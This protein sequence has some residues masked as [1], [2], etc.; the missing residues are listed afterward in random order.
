MSEKTEDSL[1]LTIERVMRNTAEARLPQMMV[2]LRENFDLIKNGRN[3]VEL[4]KH[5]KQ[6]CLVVGAGPSLTR[7]KHLHLL[8]K[9]GWNHDIISCDRML[10]PLLKRKIFPQYV[11]S[12]DGHII[13]SKF[14]KGKIVKKYAKN[15]KAVM[16]VTIHSQTVKTWMKTGGELY[17][18]V[19]RMDD[20]Q[21]KQWMSLTKSLGY[22]C[23]KTILVTG[24][25]C[26][27]FCWNLA[28]YLLYDPII[29]I[30][31]DLSYDITERMKT[32]YYNALLKYYKGDKGKAEKS[33]EK[34]YNPV[35]RRNFLIDPVFKTYH[36]F[37]M[38]YVNNV[39]T[40]TI[41]CTEGGALFGGRIVC[42]S[43]REILKNY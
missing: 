19:P 33:I 5:E 32:P 25:N 34:G 2:S 37:M 7:E 36:A 21:V 39:N 17:W 24:G 8:K 15:I 13:I 26:G 6:P 18:Y 23:L 10:K 42:A 30:G 27:S 40:T 9:H 12:V 35:W 11:G 22:L 29:L 3:V 4:P 14:Y 16:P 28:F 38:A 41:N 20:F 43:F 1:L 31:F